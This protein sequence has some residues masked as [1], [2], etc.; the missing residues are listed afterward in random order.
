VGL[1]A[2]LAAAPTAFAKSLGAAAQ[3]ARFDVKVRPAGDGGR[4]R[5]LH[6]AV[7]LGSGLVMV[8]GGYTVSEA[9]RTKTFALP[10]SGVQIYDSNQDEWFD[11]APM[12]TP[13]ARHA[14]TLLPNGMVVVVGGV[15]AE[16]LSSIEVYDPSQGTWQAA[17][18]FRAPIF[19]HFA[20]AAGNRIVIT[21]GQAGSAASVIEIPTRTS[22]AI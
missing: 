17:G 13:R 6:A 20:T 11:V 16:P 10:T 5:Y 8:S 18:T 4:T 7:D 19:D 9:V 3:P 21:G 2:A 12:L 14:M 15:A 22:A 1:A